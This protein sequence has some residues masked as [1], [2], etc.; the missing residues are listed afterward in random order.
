MKLGVFKSLAFVLF[1]SFAISCSENNENEPE[2]TYTVTVSATEGG[3]ATVNKTTYAE[4]ENKSSAVAMDGLTQRARSRQP[5]LM[6]IQAQRH[7]KISAE[8]SMI[9][10]T[11]MGRRMASAFTSR[12]SGTG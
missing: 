7:R 5:N 12:I 10:H 2:Q 1:A 6:T 11:P 9:L 8:Q 3:T 4:G